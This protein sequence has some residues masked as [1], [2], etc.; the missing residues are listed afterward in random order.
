MSNLEDV[1]EFVENPDP[2]CPCILLLDT[3]ASMSGAPIEALNQGL[4]TF[5]TDVRQDDLAKRRVEIAV[6]TFGQGGVQTLQDFVTVDQFEAPHLSA[7]G[8]T[9]MGNAIN[10]ALDMLQKRKEQYKSA[11]IL[12]YRP[13]MFM[14]TDGAP[15]DQW[16]Q[17]AKRVH[18]EE[19][20]RGMAFFAVGVANAD[21]KTLAQIAVR[22]PLLLE[23]L[24][25]TEL[26]LWL[27]QSQKRVSASQVGEQIALPPAGWST[28]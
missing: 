3:S 6:V 22:Q 14:I 16:Q 25:F 2:R 18:K 12:Y 10:L 8:V 26:F 5:Q 7:G 17:A 21:M 1:V 4:R 28:I 13:W 19:E 9:P 11:G 15:T 20:A 27:S 23:G 24:K